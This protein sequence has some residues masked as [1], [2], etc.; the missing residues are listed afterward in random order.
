MLLQKKVYLF[1]FL[2]KTKTKQNNAIR[3]IQILDI[4]NYNVK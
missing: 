1:N 4:N 3:A 2:H